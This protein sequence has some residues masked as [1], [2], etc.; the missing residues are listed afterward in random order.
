M[1]LAAESQILGWDAGTGDVRVLDD[2][3]ERASFSVVPGGIVFFQQ[4]DR[5]SLGSCGSLS[6]LG[7]EV[8]ARG[9]STN[10]GEVLL[11]FIFEFTF[12]MHH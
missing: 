8:G 10:V 1:T 3:G 2:C 11:E 12:H 4:G 9:E 6:F 7:G 5:E